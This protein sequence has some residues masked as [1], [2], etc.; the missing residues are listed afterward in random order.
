MFV[1][2]RAV[3]YMLGYDKD[4]GVGFPFRI[5]PAVLF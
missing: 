1:E 3:V 4:A 5:Y 2:V